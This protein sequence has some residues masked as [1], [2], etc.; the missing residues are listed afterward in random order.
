MTAG[1][2]ASSRRAT[3]GAGAEPA[4]GRAQ[5]A[6]ARR[7]ARQPRAEDAA[8]TAN[9]TPP[10]RTTRRPRPLPQRP[11]VAYCTDLDLLRGLTPT[12]AREHV[13]RYLHAVMEA[14]RAAAF[15]AERYRWELHL[16]ALDQ[17]QLLRGIE[18]DARK[19][20]RYRRVLASGAGFPAL[21]GLAGEGREPTENV[22]LCD[23]YHRVV[24]MRDAGIN[25]VWMWLATG[26]WRR[27]A[28]RSRAG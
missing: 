25:Y 19:L 22:L 9:A 28:T 14:E 3:R 6:P 16:V 1:E 18:L 15:E 24:A 5:R 4:T 10:T 23:G 27:P 21:I 17:I 7:P 20:R 11:A 13:T 2:M 12:Q 8:G 26:L